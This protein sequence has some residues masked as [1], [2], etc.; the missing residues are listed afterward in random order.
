MKNER[1]SKTLQWFSGLWACVKALILESD[2]SWYLVLDESSLSKDRRNRNALRMQKLSKRNS[3]A[4]QYENEISN[5]SGPLSASEAWKRVNPIS[6]IKFLI[7][8]LSDVIQTTI[9]QKCS[10]MLGD[11]YIITTFCNHLM[12][13]NFV[14]LSI[15]K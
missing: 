3:S 8:S 1:L 11:F 10:A 15:A 7:Y 4:R 14:N 12:Q 13:A 2:Q 9:T 5:S 6:M